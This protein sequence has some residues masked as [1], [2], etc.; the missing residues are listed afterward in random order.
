MSAST[1]Y[2]SD[3]QRSLFIMA[4]S[5]STEN[6]LLFLSEQVASTEVV[7]G[8]D[9]DKGSRSL[10]TS[11]VG[12]KSIVV[13]VHSKFS[14]IPLVDAAAFT[15]SIVFLSLFLN[16]FVVVFYR[17]TKTSARSYILLLAVLDCVNVLLSLLPH[18]GLALLDESLMKSAISTV[19]EFVGTVLFALYLN[20]TF[21]LALDRCIAVFIPHKFQVIAP[22]LRP[23]KIGL[24]VLQ[25]LLAVQ[26]F[27]AREISTVL[28]LI[29]LIPGWLIVLFM[30][31]VSPI[32][33]L[34]IFCKVM[35]SDR[36]MAAQRHTGT[37]N[38]DAANPR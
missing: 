2:H 4:E 11:Q 14:A 32:L 28:G 27:V 8:F 23:F 35:T 1:Y 10:M 17:K 21:Y 16:L 22:K 36:K 38:T 31:I 18:V 7:E 20:P 37:T 13:R 25:I 24:F 30:I 3:L 26:Y 9:A 34:A 6:F 12:F 15:F 29:A 5:F 19:R 33:Y